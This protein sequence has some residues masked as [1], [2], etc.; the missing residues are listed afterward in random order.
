MNKKIIGLL[1][2]LVLICSALA[3]CQAPATT[4]GPLESSA[5]AP[6]EGTPAEEVPEASAGESVKAIF[7]A[8][9]MSN[10]SNAFIAKMFQKHAAEFGFDVSIMD[11]K[12]DPATDAQNVLNAI[13]QGV[14]VIFIKPNDS[15]AIV[16]A[17]KAAKEAGVIVCVFTSELAETDQQYRDFFVGA[18]DE[19]AGEL[20]AQMFIKQFPGGAKIV[21][22]GGQA[23][24]DAAVK[25]HDG[26]IKGIEGTNITVLD[27]QN[28]KAWDTNNAMNIMQ[29]FIVK[30][31]D[32]IQGVFCHWDGGMTGIIQAELA[33]GI[34]PATLYQIGVDGNKAGFDQV[35]A[36]QQSVSCMQNF[37]TMAQ[38]AMELAKKKLVGEAIEAVNF[39]QWDI[40][41]ID[42]IDTFTYPE[43]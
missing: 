40:V 30:N 8:Q 16:P 13:A 4:S 12:G 17:L 37:E 22:I 43:W 2:V 39:A 24:D 3:A 32:D 25:R 6:V 23:G 31:G 38:K 15:N 33:A 1:L 18:N 27:F 34:D 28:T 10:P 21:E 42:T 14:K 9:S 26:F 20:V 29:D 35:K 19:Q 7:N 11:G 36:G 5:E 41:N